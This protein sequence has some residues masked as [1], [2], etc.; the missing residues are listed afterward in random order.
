MPSAGP[1]VLRLQ[2]SA[3]VKRLLFASDKD[4]WSALQLQVQD[5][6]AIKVA[7]Q[8]I[9]K[10]PLSA[11]QFIKGAANASL[12]S[13]GLK[14][15]DML[16]FKATNGQLPVA[17]AA[18]PPPAAAALPPVTLTKHC[19]HGPSGRCLHC[20]PAP[21]GAKV[22]IPCNH[23]PNASCPNC[24]EFVQAKVDSKNEQL[25]T[26]LCSH[27]SSAFCPKCIPKMDDSETKET[28]RCDCNKA[29]GQQCVICV[30]KPV[31][32]KVNFVP[33]AYYM[34]E[35]KALCR[36]AHPP[37]QT[38][39]S[40]APPK[41]EVY[42]G[43]KNC[44]RGHKPWPYGV[45]LSCAP[46]NAHLRLQKYRH[47]DGI[48][49][50]DLRPL[51]SFYRRWLQ[52]GPENQR[53]AILF[54]TY[55]DEPQSTQLRGA[56]RAQVQALYEPPQEALSGKKGVRFLK[57]PHELSVTSVAALLGLE[58]VGWVIAT[59]P[60]S[61]AKYGGDVLLSGPEIKQAA[62][63]QERYK[64][65][66]SHSKFVTVVM[67]QAQNVEPKAYQVSDQCVALER[68]GVLALA[69]DPFMLAGRTPQPG[70]LVPTVVYKDRPLQPGQEFLPDEFVVKVI[71]MQPEKPRQKFKYAEFSAVGSEQELRQYLVK[72]K[73][74]EYHDKLS[75]FNV[76]CYLPA[77]LGPQLANK[78]ITAVGTG[79]KLPADLK[80]E[81][82]RTLTAKKLI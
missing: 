17:A 82:D 66:L 59:L 37:T 6:T 56:V 68:D 28:P 80:A 57:D 30:A 34:E 3:G 2:T 41:L 40:C 47:C 49:F 77:V 8:E 27:P 35:K 63:F 25:A 21:I 4:T 39:A 20:N 81:L 65:D 43:K 70:E 24:S 73:A 7:E 74:E 44:D 23:G 13:L 22:K 51:Q 1:F 42:T 36:F 5:L 9:S 55:I 54:G 69:A 46:P 79:N 78:I 61:G 31:A 53:A 76:L 33:Y 45:C 72:H 26:W 50:E 11:P 12:A 15:G 19:Q 14:H 18:A 71:V 10:T 75:D 64:D 32:I 48:T 62:R 60:R 58:P 16:Y 38:C 67:E 52:K 29:K